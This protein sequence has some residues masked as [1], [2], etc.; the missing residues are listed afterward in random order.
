MK[1]L[2]FLL[3]LPMLCIALASCSS[4]PD[5]IS[6][7]KNP[8]ESHEDQAVLNLSFNVADSQATRADE[9]LASTDDEKKIKEIHL[10]IFDENGKLETTPSKITFESGAQAKCSVNVSLG[11]KTIYAITREIPNLTVTTETSIEK[12]ENTS[13][14]TSN[15]NSITHLDNGDAHLM[16]GK[17]SSVEIMKGSNN[18]SM[19]LTRTAAKVQLKMADSLTFKDFTFTS[20][21]YM[22][23]QSAKLMG[24]IPTQDI[25]KSTESL[26]GTYSN[27]TAHSSAGFVDNDF[28]Y[29]ES[30][31]TGY[32]TSVA[33]FTNDGV[34]F[35]L[36]ENIVSNAVS[37]N[38]SFVSVRIKAKPKKCVTSFDF[39]N[40]TF[41]K[42]DFSGTHFYAVGKRDLDNAVLSYALGPE[43]EVLV[44][45]NSGTADQYTIALNASSGSNLYST[46]IFDNGYMYYRVNI[47]HDDE[48]K[49]LRNHFYR[50]ELTGI[51]SLG[52][53]KPVIPLNADAELDVKDA[54]LEM[55][56]SVS[57]WSGQNQNSTL[58]Q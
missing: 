11:V 30:N 3:V 13:F 27:Y 1:R 6:G 12:F 7:V 17:L 5:P 42:S 43:N 41:T 39:D 33:S 16:I 20:P 40:R 47:K 14:D 18:L 46:I 53:D 32:K 2:S 8:S 24:L 51:N 48:Y 58:Q 26:H 22:V 45:A 19:T 38:T 34:C 28:Y 37:G 10:Y 35:Y 50:I 4:D 55:N 56:F 29:I 57:D 52:Y 49:V 9:E 25:C 36:P 44:F 31:Y 54:P 23:V 21:K 15:L